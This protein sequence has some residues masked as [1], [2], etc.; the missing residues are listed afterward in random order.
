M[1]RES[2]NVA[3]L[4]H[5]ACTIQTSSIDDKSRAKSQ[6][7]ASLEE[8]R[9]VTSLS[10]WTVHAAI[11]AITVVFDVSRKVN[12]DDGVYIVGVKCAQGCRCCSG[13]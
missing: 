4:V 13:I 9:E 5:P 10:L 6:L 7:A 1:L 11:G 3:R 8:N 2:K 12:I